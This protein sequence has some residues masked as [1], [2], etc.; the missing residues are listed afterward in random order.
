MEKIPISVKIAERTY[1]MTIDPEEEEKVRAAARL[2]NE[3]IRQYSENYAFNDT[4][5]L[6][7]MIAMQLATNTLKMETTVYNIDNEFAVKLK[8]IDGILT[9]QLTGGTSTRSLKDI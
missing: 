6:L 1:R 3:K 5:D 7:S 9:D 8:R 4:Q 2:I